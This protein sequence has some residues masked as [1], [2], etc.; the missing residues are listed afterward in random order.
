MRLFKY[1]TEGISELRITCIYKSNDDYNVESVYA[2]RE[3]DHVVNLTNIIEKHF[4]E[5]WEKIESI[6][7]AE[8]AAE[9]R[10]AQKEYQD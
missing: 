2:I 1:F 7:W 10:A 4:P 8:I 3:R 6:N 9:T 5:M